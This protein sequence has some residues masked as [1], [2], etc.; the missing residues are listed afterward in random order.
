MNTEIETLDLGVPD[1]VRK[2]IDRM[3]ERLPAAERELL[4]VASGVGLNFSASSVG[5]AAGRP[6]ID[7]ERAFAVLSR[8]QRFVR[9]VGPVDYPDESM[10]SRFDFVHALYRDVLYD[11]VPVGCRIEL[12]RRVGDALEISWGERSPEIA[13]ELAMHFEQSREFKR[14]G[15]YRRYAALNAQGRRAYRKLGC[16]SSVLSLCSPS[17][18]PPKTVRNARLCSKWDSVPRSCQH[19]GGVLQKSRNPMLAPAHCVKDLRTTWACFLRFGG[20]GF[21]TGAEDH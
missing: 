14:A 8:Q 3:I 12:H 15:F 17:S 20:F 7:V 16:T 11:R 6:A 1:D 9:Y 13:A 18:R 10:S 19:S 21:S 5:T 4:E 2:T